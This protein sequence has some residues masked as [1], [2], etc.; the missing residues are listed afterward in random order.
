MKKVVSSKCKAI[1][2]IIRDYVCY[3]MYFVKIEW[4]IFVSM[5]KTPLA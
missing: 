2:H 4:R 3:N 5:L 1:Y